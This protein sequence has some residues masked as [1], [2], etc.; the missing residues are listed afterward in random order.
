MPVGYQKDTL[1][2]KTYEFLITPLE[3]I[4]TLPVFLHIEATPNPNEKE[5]LQSYLSQAPR[6]IQAHGGVPIAT[7]DVERALD[8]ANSP[9]VFVVV[10]FPNRD[11][12][13]N[14]FADSAY[15]AIVPVRDRGFSHLRFFITSERI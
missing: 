1:L 9:D 14:F 4:M 6:L 3:K 8:D 7:Y 5:A 11:A 13:D 15:Q 2:N 10:S 12:I